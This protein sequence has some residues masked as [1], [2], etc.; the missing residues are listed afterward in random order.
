MCLSPSSS[1]SLRVRPSVC[2]MHLFPPEPAGAAYWAGDGEDSKARQRQHEDEAR[3]RPSAFMPLSPG[4]PLFTSLQPAVL[5]SMQHES[6]LTRPL[7]PLPCLRLALSTLARRPDSIL[8]SVS[9]PLL[10]S[11]PC[12]LFPSSPAAPPC[13]PPTTPPSTSTLPW[14]PPLSPSS[15]LVLTSRQLFSVLLAYAHPRES[16]V[17]TSPTLL[18]G[19][20]A[21]P[22]RPLPPV[23]A[24]L[25]R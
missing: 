16:P 23:S 19:P 2:S 4:L 17:L 21:T 1:S 7:S 8:L 12:N 15:R 18:P 10:L 9:R 13:S 6:S 11:F 3:S 14:S 25:H 20:P 24:L 5:R 22:R